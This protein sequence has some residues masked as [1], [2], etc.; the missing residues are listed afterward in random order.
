MYGKCFLEGGGWPALRSGLVLLF[1][2][3]IM[4]ILLSK[5]RVTKISVCY[6]TGENYIG[7]SFIRKKYFCL[8][9]KIAVLRT[10]ATNKISGCHPPPAPPPPPPPTHTHTRTHTRSSGPD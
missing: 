6:I 8:S 7:S 2:Q 3:V 10:E 4:I 1:K 5:F 9:T